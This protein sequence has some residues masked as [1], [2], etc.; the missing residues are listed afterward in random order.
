MHRAHQ[1]TGLRGLL[2]VHRFYAASFVATMSKLARLHVVLALHNGL[3]EIDELA[4][5]LDDVETALKEQPISRAVTVQMERFRRMI[6]GGAEPHELSI[7]LRELHENIIADL[8]AHWF[9]VIPDAQ[10]SLY[11][12][13]SPPFGKAVDAAFPEAAFDVACAARCL[14]LDEWTACVFHS[15]RVVELG[16]R[17][18]ARAL[19]VPMTESSDYENWGNLIDQIEK[20]IRLIEQ[21]PRS[22]D[23]AERSR[24][25]SE[26][27]TQVRYFKNA[28]RNHVS[29]SRAAY[30]ETE[31]RAVF[32]HVQALMQQLA[33]A[34]QAVP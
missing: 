33:L 8:T 4:S 20:A 30:G 14:A 9:L 28:W 19:S 25:Y 5:A 12:Q 10:R 17:R 21:E 7:M 29:H 11:E 16:L 26:V 13:A 3:A 15:M 32:M 18:V 24:F 23:K 34:E 22:A 1:A 27:G 31:A 6:N 2:G